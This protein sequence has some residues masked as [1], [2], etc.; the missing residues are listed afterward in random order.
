[1]VGTLVRLQLK[2]FGRSLSGSP[3]KVIG[4]AIMGLWLLGAWVA[5]AMGLWWLRGH[6]A[7][8]H[9][10]IATVGLGA[11]TLSWPLMTLLASG[12]DQTL[13]PGRFAL[14]P[15]RARQLMPGLL[16]AGL[17]GLGAVFT[18]LTT[19]AFVVS[20]STSVVAAL[21]ALVAAMLGLAT[22]LLLARAFT[23]AFSAAL[24]SRRYRDAAAA[25]L[26]VAG[27]SI[28]VAMQ[29]ISNWAARA[30]L[31]GSLWGTVGEVVGW[32]PVGW[33]WALP[34]DAARGHWLPFVARLVLA[35]ALVA[36]LWRVWEFYLDRG[37]VSPLETSGGGGKVKAT[38]IVDRMVP[39]GV[40]GAVAGRSL[41]YWRRDPRHLVSFIAAALMPLLMA[42]PMLM[43]GQADEMGAGI[44]TYPV[45]GMLIMSAMVIAQEINYDGSALWTTISAGVRGRDDRLGRLLLAAW[46]FL[47]MALVMDVVFLVLAKDLRHAPALVGATL[48]ALFVAAAVGT[49][50]GAF[51]QSAVPPAGQNAFG[52]GSG[53]GA[54]AVLWAFLSMAASGGLSLPFLIPAGL[55]GSRPWLGWLVLV[56]GPLYGLLLVWGSTIWGGRVLDRSWPEVL[57]RV[58]WKG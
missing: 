49:V 1:M 7:Q 30:S 58:T 44:L 36:G 3:G 10:A 26:G 25:I 45:L 27:M 38:S 29:G 16:V 42:A 56:V 57:E 41:R 23:S 32:T 50:A 11:L 34:W 2:L 5:L 24:S 46:L 17:F 33:A 51:N 15:V 43:N 18:A 55:S 12:S 4:M 35:V 8:A 6:G 13:D 40:A 48:G 53:G 47:P 22:C 9:G 37:L 20:W 39:R 19:A 31:D 54:E 52:K 14:F 28:G 21:A